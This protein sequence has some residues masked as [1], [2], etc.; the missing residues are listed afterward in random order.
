MFEKIVLAVD[1]PDQA[2]GAVAAAIDLATKSKGEILLVHV[3]DVGLVSRESYDLETQDDA[4]LLTRALLDVVAERGVAARCELRAA[5]T[6]NIADEILAAAKGFEADTI[7]LGSRG[8][9]DF[10][11]LLLGSV[12]H[13]VI[14]LAACPVVV[15]RTPIAAAARDRGEGQVSSA[16]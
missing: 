8:L 10:A 12:A 13:R 3:H 15:A 1:T 11:G 16:A 7:V 6:V 2:R 5:K 14:Q 9:G 4:R